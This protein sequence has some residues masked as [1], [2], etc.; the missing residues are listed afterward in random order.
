MVFN[1]L[2]SFLLIIL[3]LLIIVSKKNLIKIVIGMSLLD[4]GINLILISIGYRLNG[5]AP[6]F[7]NGLKDKLSIPISCKRQSND[8]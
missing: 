2:G 3:G 7:L 8:S 6:I 1:Y 4:Y 5:T